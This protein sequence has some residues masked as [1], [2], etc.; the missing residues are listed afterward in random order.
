MYWS[1]A[2]VLQ[3]VDD[4]LFAGLLGIHIRRALESELGQKV[5]ILFRYRSIFVTQ[6]TTIP[7]IFPA[8]V[9]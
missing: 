8:A 2:P 7:E 4:F 1:A 5:L 6:T 3:R 9:R